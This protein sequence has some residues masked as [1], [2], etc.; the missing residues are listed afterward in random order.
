MSFNT[1][2][3]HAQQEFDAL[4]SGE[5]LVLPCTMHTTLQQSI[6]NKDSRVQFF[7]SLANIKDIVCTLY[8]PYSNS[9]SA[10]G[11]ENTAVA[12]LG[13]ALLK[14]CNYLWGG[15][16]QIFADTNP[17]LRGAPDAENVPAAGQVL[18]A[19]LKETSFQIQIGAKQIP[20]TPLKGGN[21][22]SHCKM[23]LGI[24]ALR[25]GWGNL[26]S[27]DISKKVFAVNLE[28]YTG[29]QLDGSGDTT[30]AGESITAIFAD[31]GTTNIYPEKNYMHLRS[32]AK[33]ELRT[34]SVRKLD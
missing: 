25:E 9:H 33:V 19:N 15:T 34:G 11:N 17:A 5:G 29:T 21:L 32:S 7:R 12:H 24:E 26:H 10:E 3:S 22:V 27:Y 8:R 31:A 14:E 16:S 28:K 2:S 30:R 4:I 18:D 23:S 1:L 6:F 13:R 20:E